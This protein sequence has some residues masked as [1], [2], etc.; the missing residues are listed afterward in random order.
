MAKRAVDL[1]AF[2]VAAS[3]LAAP[4][5]AGLPVAPQPEIAGGLGALVA[6]GLG[7]RWL[8]NRAKH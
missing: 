7:Y 8:R 2:V 1:G 4:A 5:M 6:F 3:M